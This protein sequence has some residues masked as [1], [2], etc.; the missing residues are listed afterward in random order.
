MLAIAQPLNDG[1]VCPGQNTTTDRMDSTWNQ[2][3]LTVVATWFGFDVDSHYVALAHP[4]PTIP[5]TLQPP[6]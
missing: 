3:S 4:D 1:C 6:S 2:G 5:S